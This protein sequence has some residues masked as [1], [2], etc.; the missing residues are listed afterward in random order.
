MDRFTGQDLNEIKVLD[1]AY[2]SEQLVVVL[3]FKEP[4]II[5]AAV[6]DTRKKSQDLSTQNN[7]LVAASDAY[8]IYPKSA[9]IT[10]SLAKDTL[11]VD[12]TL[13][14]G[15]HQIFQW[16]DSKWQKVPE[17]APAPAPSQNG[18]ADAPPPPP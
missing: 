4:P 18:A 11:S 14:G 3:K 8:N 17:A 16:K 12:V 13:L 5:Y 15:K 7:L 2:E 9:T 6:V 1:V 10:G